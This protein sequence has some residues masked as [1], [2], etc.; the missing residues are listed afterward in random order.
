MENTIK[1]RLISLLEEFDKIHNSKVLIP[2]N[3]KKNEKKKKNESLE[4]LENK[5]QINNNNNNN[6]IETLTI[7]ESS[8]IY[9]PKDSSHLNVLRIINLGTTC[10]K[11]I[12]NN[13]ENIFHTFYSPKG[14]QYIFVNTNS[15]VEFIFIEKENGE[16][17][18]LAK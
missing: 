5:I 3:K 8:P 2:K 11:V 15:Y 12:A 7:S 18:W 13:N 9:L 16:K 10:L 17:L 4:N 6:S 14:S 1:D